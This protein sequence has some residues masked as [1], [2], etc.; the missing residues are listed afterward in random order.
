MYIRIE[1]EDLTNAKTEETMEELYG[2]PSGTCLT[3]KNSLSI[4]PKIVRQTKDLSV[5][6][7]YLDIDILNRHYYG[8]LSALSHIKSYYGVKSVDILPIEIKRPETDEEY[9][10]IEEELTK[11][12][13]KC[14]I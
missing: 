10:K 8:V 12:M 3:S 4:R 5:G 7:W 13:D 6:F 9:H 14:Y 11:Y 2:I 1:F